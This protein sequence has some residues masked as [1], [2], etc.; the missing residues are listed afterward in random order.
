MSQ[1]PEPLPKLL[2]IHGA[3]GAADQLAPLAAA[4]GAAFTVEVLELPGHGRT[5][6]LGSTF[7]MDAFCAAIAGRIEAL[8]W[9]PARVFGYSMGGFAACRLAL[10][11]PA[12]VGSLATLG[13][14]F[15]WSPAIASRESAMLDAARIREK[16][17][18]FAALLDERHQAL[19]WEQVLERTKGLLAQL[20]KDGG[21]QP[22]AVAQLA[23]RL[24]VLV[25]DRDQ[26]VDLDHSRRLALAAPRGSLEVLPEAGHPL[27]RVP[28][29]RLV[30]ALEAF[31]AAGQGEGW[32]GRPSTAMV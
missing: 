21:I 6:P 15:D 31:F 2:L 8:G 19:A 20:G 24:R 12:L 13:T 9:A 11:R 25:G 17:P 16:V 22:E 3:L 28:M 32:S 4:L 23:P 10:A 18:A 27:E 7:G 14:L 29:P 1:A 5:A 30:A 26:S